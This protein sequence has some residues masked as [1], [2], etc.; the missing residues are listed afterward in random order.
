MANYISDYVPQVFGVFIQ[1][2]TLKK[3]SVP[4]VGKLCA[5]LRGSLPLQFN[6]QNGAC[7][8]IYCE[9]DFAT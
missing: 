7:A 6:K 9:S 8:Y 5:L 3:D 2:Q 1:L 4:A